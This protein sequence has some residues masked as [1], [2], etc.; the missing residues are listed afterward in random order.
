MTKHFIFYIR[1]IF[2]HIFLHFNFLSATFCITFLSS[3]TAT[4]INKQILSVLF[5]INVSALLA[6]SCL[7]PWFHSSCIFMFTYRLTYVWLP[8]SCCFE[9]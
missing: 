6:R 3:N 2:L 8:V 7:T 1:W 9:A 4:S 5:L